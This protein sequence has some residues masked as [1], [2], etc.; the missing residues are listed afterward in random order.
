MV[1]KDKDRPAVFQ[2]RV[3]L[4]PIYGA[5]PTQHNSPHLGTQSRVE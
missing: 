2:D 5:Y 1:G 3:V 4:I